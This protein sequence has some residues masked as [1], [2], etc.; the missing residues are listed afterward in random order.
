MKKKSNRPSLHIG[1]DFSARVGFSQKRNVMGSIVVAP[2]EHATS[3]DSL[4]LNW[5]ARSIRCS[6]AHIQFHLPIRSH[7]RRHTLCQYATLETQILPA[8]LELSLCNTEKDTYVCRS[9]QSFLVSFFFGWFCVY[10]SS[11]PKQFI[12][13]ACDP[14]ELV[15]KSVKVH[16]YFEKRKT[17]SGPPIKQ[18]KKELK[19]SWLTTYRYVCDV[20]LL[21]FHQQVQ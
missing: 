15:A 7:S 13:F 3:I 5:W 4:T 9:F 21:I 12:G 18:Q 20:S 2:P 6:R 17:C 8:L 14:H 10:C 1:C 11:S 16:K 19:E